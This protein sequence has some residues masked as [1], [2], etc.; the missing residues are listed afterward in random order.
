M[1]VRAETRLEKFL[2]Q[3]VDVATLEPWAIAAEELL[4][5]TV[6]AKRVFDWQRCLLVADELVEELGI[7]SLAAH[8]DVLTAG[9][10][11]REEDLAA[12]VDAARAGINPDLP[13]CVKADS[14][15]C[16]CPCVW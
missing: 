7:K 9:L 12:A 11:Q 16:A 6:E 15:P 2:G 5:R 10:R 8:S 4:R 1:L 3:H 13:S 14:R